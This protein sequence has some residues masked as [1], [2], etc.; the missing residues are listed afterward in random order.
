MV[1]L[2]NQ[3][4]VY[5]RKSQIKNEKSETRSSLARCRFRERKAP[6]EQKTSMWLYINAIRTSKNRRLLLSLP[7]CIGGSSFPL[8]VRPS[9]NWKSKTESLFNSSLNTFASPHCSP[10]SPYT[11]SS[12]VAPAGSPRI[13]HRKCNRFSSSLSISLFLI[14]PLASLYIL[15][16]P[17]LL[18]QVVP[19]YKIQNAI[20]FQISFQY[21]CFSSLLYPLSIYW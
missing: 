1:E 5:G 20:I 14:H 13:L 19:E 9:P 16:A 18:Q 11:A 4:Q 8:A 3:K 6:P 17:V 15:V 2:E 12:C 7:L 21:F 10:L